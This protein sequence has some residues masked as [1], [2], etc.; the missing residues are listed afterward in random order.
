MREA[1]VIWLQI[2]G[3][4]PTM[5]PHFQNAYRYARLAG[6]MLTISTNGSLLFRPN[7]L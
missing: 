3:G 1:G 6:M 2:T 5:E 4:E 7:L